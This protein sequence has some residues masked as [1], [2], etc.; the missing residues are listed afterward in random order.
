MDAPDASTLAQFYSELLGWPIGHEEAGTA[1]IA[2]P[3]GS[4]YVV[5]QKATDYQAP[6]WPPV[7]GQQ[8]PMMHFDFQVGDLDSAV[9]EAVALGATLQQRLHQNAGAPDTI[10]PIAVHHIGPTTPLP[11]ARVASVEVV[12]LLRTV[13]T[14][15]RF[16]VTFA[17]GAQDN[18]CLKGLLDVDEMTKL[19]GSTCVLEGDFYLKLAPQLNVQAM[20]FGAAADQCSASSF[21]HR[22]APGS[23]RARSRVT[24][25]SRP[26]SRT[27]ACTTSSRN[28]T[29]R[30]RSS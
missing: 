3:G 24:S 12:E 29:S 4:I 2:A 21:S 16:A 17:D 27:A 25:C 28:A 10:V 6:T 20:S 30:A 1:I 19:G 8:R 15:V 22:S 14:K 13:A 18:Y 5:F 26:A 11:A 7:D 23:S 9:E